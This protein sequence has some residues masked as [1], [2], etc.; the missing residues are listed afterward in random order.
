MSVRNI[1]YTVD[2]SICYCM[3][4][5]K[6]KKYKKNTEYVLCLLYS[7]YAVY[8]SYSSAVYCI[9]STLYILY[10]PLVYSKQTVL[11]SYL[12]FFTLLYCIIIIMDR[13]IS[14]SCEVSV[15]I[16]YLST[17]HALFL[18]YLQFVL[19]F[20][21]YISKYLLL[22]HFVLI[23]NFITKYKIALSY[24]TRFFIKVVKKKSFYFC[25]EVTKCLIYLTIIVEIIY[26]ANNNREM[27]S[28]IIY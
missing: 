21:F 16:F 11:I 13:L 17:R 10:V 4:S 26:I 12:Y 19:Y 7:K 28:I 9:Y 8:F 27:K 14:Q 2:C 23:E 20:I 5:V 15:F 24:T 25:I 18:L 6:C 3:C 1:Q 22:P